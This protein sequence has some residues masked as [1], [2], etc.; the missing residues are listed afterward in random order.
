MKLRD[1]LRE[2]RTIDGLAF[3]AGAALMMLVAWWL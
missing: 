3:S 1:L 2:P